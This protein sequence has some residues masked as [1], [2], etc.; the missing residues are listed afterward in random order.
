MELEARFARFGEVRR[1]DVRAALGDDYETSSTVNVLALARP[2][3]MPSAGV[4]EL[5]WACSGRGRQRMLICPV[6][7]QGRRTL[8]TDGRGGFGCA[9][10]VRRRTRHQTEKRTVR[11][12]DL[13]GR[14]ED[15]L[16]RL[17]RH[18]TGPDALSVPSALLEQLVQGD[19]AR[20]RASSRWCWPR[21]PLPAGA[22]DEEQEAGGRASATRSGSRRARWCAGFSRVAPVATKRALA[23]AVNQLRDARHLGAL[24]EAMAGHIIANFTDAAGGGTKYLIETSEG[25]TEVPSVTAVLELRAL[26]VQVADVARARIDQLLVGGP[27]AVGPIKLEHELFAADEDTDEAQDWSARAVPK[28]QRDATT[29]EPQG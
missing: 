4:I 10:C 13:G 29:K 25:T 16:L 14:E 27:D 24:A 21:W 11:Y 12:R 2:G 5:G 6:C 26:L 17:L 18:R 7:A 15:R 9:G 28:W 22:N 3:Q 1:G 23:T 20:L 19:V 8:H